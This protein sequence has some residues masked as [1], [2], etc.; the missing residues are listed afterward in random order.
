MRPELLK[1]RFMKGQS[2]FSAT[3]ISDIPATPIAISQKL[4]KLQY[5]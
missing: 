3:S 5:K 1:V 2:K 4:E